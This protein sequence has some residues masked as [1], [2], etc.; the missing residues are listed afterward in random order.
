[1]LIVLVLTPVMIAIRL[2]IRILILVP[3]LLPQVFLGT[4]PRARCH[5]LLFL[6]LKLAVLLLG[7]DIVVLVDLV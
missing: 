1:M 3:V 5:V 7:I 2:V 6:F 4:F